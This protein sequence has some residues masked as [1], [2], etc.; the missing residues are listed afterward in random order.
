ML[1]IDL[2]LALFILLGLLTA[3]TLLTW[4]LA[5]K[6]PL[7]TPPQLATW[8]TAPIGLILLSP[9][10]Q[11]QF[12]NQRAHHLLHADHA[13]LDNSSTY[14]QLRQRLS[15]QVATHHFHLT[16]PSDNTLD[17]WCSLFDGS[18]LILLQ[19]ITSQR[20]REKALQLFWGG[21]AH[22]I[23]TPLTSVLAHLEIARSPTT[24]PDIQQQSLDIIHQQ[25]HRLTNLLQNTL[26]L[27]R[28]KA[29]MIGD[30]TAVDIILVAEEAIAELILT[31][32]EQNI[33]FNLVY[34]SP[35]PRI[36]GSPDKLKQVFL[37]LLDNTL[38][39]CQAGD[40]VTVSLTGQKQHVQC[41]IADTGSGIPA[42]HLPQLTEL[43]YRARRDVPGSGLGLAIVDEIVRQHDGRLT[44]QSCTQVP[45][46]GTTITFTLPQATS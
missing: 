40:E 15:D 31:A 2:K 6:L 30:K 39:Y 24:P 26:E 35:L 7:F 9:K 21:A 25:A 29:T 13:P 36:W 16:T 45:Q 43:F 18:T 44:I 38:K 8:Q 10:G 27:G 5:S 42:Q 22:E 12:A 17:I 23:R 1:V 14:T 11:L 32:E 20:Q 4:H 3:V 28:L 46:T 41:Q 34:Q 19:D 33:G 37:N